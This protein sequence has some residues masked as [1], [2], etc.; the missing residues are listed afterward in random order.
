MN[1]SSSLLTT[2]TICKWWLLQSEI[3]PYENY[4]RNLFREPLDIFASAWQYI[5]DGWNGFIAL[6]SGFSPSEALSGMASGII[7]MFDNV[8]HTIKGSFLKSWNWIVGKLNK[9]PGVDISLAAEPPP[10]MT[11][12]TLLTGGEL[13]GIERG[14]ISK[15]MNSNSKSVTDNSRKIGTVNIYPKETLSPGQLQEWQELNP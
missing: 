2:A 8:W 10:A 3:L 1:D 12:N 11:T 9:I 5:S 13:K 4:L 15:T 7:S 6:L 14:G